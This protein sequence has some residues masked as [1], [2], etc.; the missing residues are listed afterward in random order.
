[1]SFNV[2]YGTKKYMLYYELCMLVS[3]RYTLCTDQTL[4]MILCITRGIPS[5]HVLKINNEVLQI[6]GQNL[7]FT[8]L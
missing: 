1:M 7:I 2:G 8:V 5:R 3:L 6:L 4:Y